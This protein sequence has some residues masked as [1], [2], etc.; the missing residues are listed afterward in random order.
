[1]TKESS[2]TL[3]WITLALLVI[4]GLIVLFQP[5]PKVSVDTSVLATAIA[6]QIKVQTQT[7][8]LTGVE[9]RITDIEITLN[10]DKDWEDEAEKIATDEWERK[11]YKDI[12]DAIDNIYEDISDRDDIIYVKEDKKTTFSGM[13]VKDRDATV[14]QYVKVKY[15]DKDG[16]NRKIYLTI[17]TEIEEGEVEN[18]DITEK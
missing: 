10:E 5:A 4:V 14:I 6:S 17:T 13:D 3:Q 1:M 8:N 9:N 11:D 7:T 18:Q 2:I 16:N 12:F 15:E